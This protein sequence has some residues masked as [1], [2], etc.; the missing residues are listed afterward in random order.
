MSKNLRIILKILM[1]SILISAQ[2]A[3]FIISS[4]SAAPRLLWPSKWNPQ[5][6]RTYVSKLGY[7]INIP[8]NYIGSNQ[9]RGYVFNLN[10]DNL[11]HVYFYGNWSMAN[12]TKT[13]Y[14]VF[15]YDPSG[16]LETYHTESAGLMEHLGTTVNEPFFRP[17]KD[18]NY[19]ILLYNDSANGVATVNG[20]LM[21]IEHLDINRWYGSKVY[22]EGSDGVTSKPLPN[23]IWIYEFNS[24][25]SHMEISVDVPETLDMYEVRLYLMAV[26]DQGRG[27]TLLGAPI[28]WEPG[29]YGRH[30]RDK[31]IGGF[32]TNFTDYR[33]NAFASCEYPGEDMLINYTSPYSGNLL[34]HLV[35][36][37][38][39]GSGNLSFI[40]KS[41]FTKP[42]LQLTKPNSVYT[43][44]EA[45]VTA[46]SN[47]TNSG[48]EHVKLSYSV[49]AGLSWG[50]TAMTQSQPQVYTGKIPA[51]SA[52]TQV[53]YKVEA[54]DYAL[55]K[56][57]EE[58][59]YLSKDSSSIQLAAPTTVRGGQSINVSGSIIPLAADTDVLIQY[60][61][62]SGLTVNKTLKTD[63]LGLFSD[64]YTPSASGLWRISASW[65]GDLQHASSAG[66][67]ALTVE[68]QTHTLDMSASSGRVT[69]GE[70]FSVS[71]TLSPALSN[72][73][74]NVIITDPSGNAVIKKVAVSAQGAYSYSF[75]PNLKGAWTVSALFA[76]DGVHG[77]AVSESF[78][79]E[80]AE[81][82]NFLFVAFPVIPIIA[83]VA[84]KKFKGSSES[85]Y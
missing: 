58:G 52:G 48:I 84:I 36:L 50:S 77:S 5:W 74:V 15:V 55:N 82:F 32:S 66:S 85:D 29:L 44:G 62:S 8:T 45:T 70:D 16:N 1:A 49:D 47:D 76:G 6:P 83:I 33:G 7:P 11:Y 69:L 81:P 10:N 59:S 13:D 42:Y 25:A 75:K 3:P 23:T 9:T 67:A 4:V 20:T 34:Y 51:Q 53:L 12:G 26:P 72:A 17:K 2:I 41:D 22:T 57:V 54:Q 14:D 28:A 37:A 68:K 65:G 73:V 78:T 61:S 27:E 31:N 80:V 21:V 64:T 40:I 19:T 35:F 24:S 79:L 46:M 56:A 60:A 30:D 18:G 39:R 71:G 43:G 63:S 38:E